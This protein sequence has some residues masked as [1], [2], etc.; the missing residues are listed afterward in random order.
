MNRFIHNPDCFYEI[1]DKEILVAIKGKAEIVV[2]SDSSLFLWL[3]LKK[4]KTLDN[5]VALLCGQFDITEDRA[6]RD[7]NSFLRKGQ[8][9]KIILRL[10]ETG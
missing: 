1:R 3:A 2:L 10:L 8:R 5:L 7:I 4:P 6:H 9:A